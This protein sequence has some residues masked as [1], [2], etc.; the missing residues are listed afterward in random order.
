MVPWDVYMPGGAHV[1]RYFGK[2][3][4]YVDLFGFIRA[5]QKHLDD[6]EEAATAGFEMEENRYGEAPPVSI[7]ENAK[8]SAVV[9]VVPGQ[10][11]CG[12]VV[13]LVD[14]STEPKLTAV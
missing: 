6:H 5:N 14:Y 8:V 4:Q 3:E 7:V 11:D 12:A 1:P 13:H 9:R 2:R 10:P